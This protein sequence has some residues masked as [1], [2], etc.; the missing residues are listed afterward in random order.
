MAGN[1]QSELSFKRRLQDHLL[2]KVLTAI[3]TKKLPASGFS[4]RPLIHS[5]RQVHANANVM[6]GIP[7]FCMQQYTIGEESVG[8]SG[9]FS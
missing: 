7:Y 2:C 5:L 9:I 8:L 4:F 6:L 1:L 3:V